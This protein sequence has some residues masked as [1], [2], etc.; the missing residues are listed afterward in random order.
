MVEELVGCA[1]FHDLAVGH[2]HDAV[3]HAAGEVHLVRDDDHRHALLGQTDHDLEHLVDHLGVQRARGLV[4]KHGLGLHGKRTCDGYTLLLAA[5][6]LCGHLIGLLGNAHA[7]Q[8]V[9]GALT[10]LVLGHAQH[11]DRSQHDVLQ[12]G[13]MCKQVEL[14]KY[15]AQLG[16]HAGKILAFL[17]QGLALDEDLA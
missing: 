16:T 7:A 10:S 14:L 13:H 6:E 9:H 17:W 8:Q 2:K 11:I 4:K 3:G 5:R 12:Y 15:H 1:G